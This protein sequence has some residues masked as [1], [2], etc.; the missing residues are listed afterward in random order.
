[1]IAIFAAAALL[2]AQVLPW[3]SRRAG[4]RAVV[5]ASAASLSVL[6]PALVALQR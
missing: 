4:N 1:M 3:L 6:Q 2:L 5:P